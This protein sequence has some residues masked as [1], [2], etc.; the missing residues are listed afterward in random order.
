MLVFG[1]S[2]YGKLTKMLQVRGCVL[3]LEIVFVAQ[4]EVFVCL[5][6]VHFFSLAVKLLG[7]RTGF[8]FF[9]KCRLFSDTYPLKSTQ[10]DKESLDDE[11]FCANL[12]TEPKIGSTWVQIEHFS[13]NTRKWQNFDAQN[14][15]SKF[16]LVW[17]PPTPH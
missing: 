7:P 15:A 11:K 3:V 2:D 12:I 14:T 4:C 1:M 8:Q 17:E 5:D 6:F 9:K 10:F 13:P 16:L